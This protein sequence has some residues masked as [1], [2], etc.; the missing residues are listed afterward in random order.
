MCPWVESHAPSCGWQPW[1]LPNRMK[2]LSPQKILLPRV[3]GTTASP[4][5]LELRGLAAWQA[6]RSWAVC[7]HAC[8]QLLPWLRATFAMVP[9]AAL[10]GSDQW[11]WSTAPATGPVDSAGSPQCVR[12]W[13]CRLL[14]PLPLLPS[15]HVRVRCPGPLGA[16]SPVRALCAVWVCCWWL[17][18]SSPPL[19]IF[20]FSFIFLLCI[21]FVLFCLFF[22]MEKGARAHCRHRHGQLV[23]RCSSVVSS[24]LHRGCFV[25]GR[26][27][28]LRLALFDVHGYGSGWVWLVASLL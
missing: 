13:G 10:P 24:G 22:E 4:L 18:P 11:L 15:V 5:W 27:P 21:C 17:R 26:A 23:Q 28:G 8:H 6:A 25:G 20:F 12:P 3:H 2:Y 1:G 14:R 19:L 9:D 16:C 7:R